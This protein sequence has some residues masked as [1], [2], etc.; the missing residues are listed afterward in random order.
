MAFVL[1]IGMAQC[2]KEQ[3]TPSENNG[4]NITLKVDGGSEKL[5]VYPATG[6]VIFTAGDQIYVG[7][8]GKYV[9]TLTFDNGLFQGTISGDLSTEDYL[10]FYF[11]GNKPTSPTELAAG[12]TTYTVDISD[13][14]M[15][16][17]AIS[18]A[19]SK[20]KYSPTTTAYTAR[21]LNKSALV[22]FV[23]SLPTDQPITVSGMRNEVQID[24]A[25][26][27]LAPTNNTGGIT[28]YSESTTDK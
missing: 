15:Y 28:L 24:F 18:Y 21:L 12:T 20:E 1:L 19:P 2:K 8:N 5:N 23:T 16:L 27:T 10:H 3:V 6:A 7:N 9:G 25:N 17:P 11:V 26:N 13:Q 22:K 14:T 4:V